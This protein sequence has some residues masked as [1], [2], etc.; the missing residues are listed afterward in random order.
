MGGT[1][2][3][4]IYVAKNLRKIFLFCF[5]AIQCDIWD[6]SFLTKDQTCAPCGGSAVSLPLDHQGSPCGRYFYF[7]FP[8]ISILLSNISHLNDLLFSLSSAVMD[9]TYAI[10]H[11]NFSHH[12]KPETQSFWTVHKDRLKAEGVLAQSLS[13]KCCSCYDDHHGQVAHG[14][15]AH[16]ATCQSKVWC[17]WGF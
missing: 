1:P 17:I 12:R 14:S 7:A 4:C 16:A 8:T 2:K 5:L 15:L 13:T 6:V 10:P 9:I 11:G 3:L